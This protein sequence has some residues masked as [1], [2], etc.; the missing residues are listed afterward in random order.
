MESSEESESESE[1]SLEESESES[2]ESS[3]EEEE[4]N[5][6]LVNRQMDSDEDSGK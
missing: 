1:E 3:E 6:S 5:R 4:D 2:E